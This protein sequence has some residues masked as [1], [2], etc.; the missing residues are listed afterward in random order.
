MVTWDDSEYSSSKDEQ[1]ETINICFMA[2]GDE[3]SSTFLS[4]SDFDIDELFDTYNE[5]M[6]EYK[7]LN[8]KKKK[9][10]TC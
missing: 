10:L 7:E 3:V 8:K 4:N 5:L 2:Q 9:K 6:I 1:K